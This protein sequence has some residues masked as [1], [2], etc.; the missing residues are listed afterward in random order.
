MQR[1]LAVAMACTLAACAPMTTGM[2]TPESSDLRTNM[3]RLWTDHVVWTRGYIVAAV[4]DDP[5]AQTQAAR[6]LRNQEDIGNAIV[7]FYGAAAGEQLSTLLKEHI[8]IAVD[9][10]TAAKAGDTA[11][12]NDADRRWRVNA[13]QIAT[14]L[15]TANPNWPKATL[16]EMLNTHLDLTTREAVARLT[17]DWTTDTSTFDAILS[18][19]LE[20]ADALTSGIQKQFPGRG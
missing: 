17:R 20:M 7:P 13:D 6:L 12:Q 4:A 10:L 1:I 2:G 9:L 18:Q 8:T 3:R 19:A 15:S 14:F 11:A 16:L 5:S